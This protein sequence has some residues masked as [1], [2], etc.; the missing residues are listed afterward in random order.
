[1]TPASSLVGS[2]SPN[3]IALSSST[4]L[5]IATFRSYNMNGLVRHLV[6]GN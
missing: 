1:M 4:L 6:N 3:N 5:G 2:I